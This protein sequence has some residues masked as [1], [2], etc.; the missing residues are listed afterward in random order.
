MLCILFSFHSNPNHNRAGEC[1]TALKVFDLLD[2]VFFVLRKK[3]SQVTPLH[4][5]HHSIMPFT[6]WLAY[7]FAPVPSSAIVLILNSF[8]H[9]VMY[10]YYELANQ[11]KN[12]WWKKYITVLQLIQ[13]YV[14][15]VHALHTFLIPGCNYPKWIAGLQ[16]AESV[17]FIVTFT[18]FYTQSY[19]RS[20][21]ID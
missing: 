13:F 20:S 1:Y 16:V 10:Y 19:K 6:S 5:T 3:W 14:V 2:T 4:V 18:R 7:K 21:K 11:G 8:V 9:T 17:F 12:V 15:L